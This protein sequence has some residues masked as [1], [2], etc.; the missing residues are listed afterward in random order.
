MTSLVATLRR[1]LGFFMPDTM[2][3]AF[4]PGWI[5]LIWLSNLALPLPPGA[6]AALITLGPILALWSSVHA[7]AGKIRHARANGR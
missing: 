5:A 1:L 4:V 2:L 7:Q 3:A 6:R